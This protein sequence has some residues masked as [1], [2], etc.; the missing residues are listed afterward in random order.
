[1][2]DFSQESQKEE[3]FLFRVLVGAESLRQFSE[4][5]DDKIKPISRKT[6]REYIIKVFSRNQRERRRR[7]DTKQ[8]KRD[9]E[10]VL[11]SRVV[12]RSK[13]G[14]GLSHHHHLVEN[15]SEASPIQL[16]E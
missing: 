7:E 2:K 14:F 15:L 8:R 5:T 1:M 12:K 11:A 13:E 10:A 9:R 6:T 4:Q 16:K 3:T